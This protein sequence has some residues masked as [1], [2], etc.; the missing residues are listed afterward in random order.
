MRFLRVTM[1][2]ILLAPAAI[3][4]I[5]AASN[6]AVLIANHDKFP[7]LMN[8]FRG[9]EVGPE[10]MLDNIHCVMTNETRLNFLA[11]IFD[12]KSNS[13]SVGDL[14]L[15]LGEWMWTFCPFVWAAL[16]ARR[17]LAC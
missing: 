12:L 1:L 7:V 10:G 2:W 9:F 16:V 17:L 15:I 14:L 11:D 5:G 13:Y 3:G 4:F 6:Q 8:N